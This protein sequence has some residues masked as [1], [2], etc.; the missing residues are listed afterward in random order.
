MKRTF[1]I[2]SLILCCICSMADQYDNQYFG[3]ATTIQ[4]EKAGTL[5]KEL[6]KN[7]EGF[8]I[9]QIKGE[10]SDKDMKTLAKLTYLKKLSLRYANIEKTT[11]FPTLPNLEVLFLP[12][13]QVIPLE[14][15]DM[16][17]TN[18]KIKVLLLSSFIYSS[19]TDVDS[20]G[21]NGTVHQHRFITFSSLQKVILSRNSGLKIIK[22]KEYGLQ[23]TEPILVDTIVYSPQWSRNDFVSCPDMFK[24]R[25]YEEING[26]LFY[27][28]NEPVDFS[29]VEAVKAPQR[30]WVN[31][32]GEKTTRYFNRPLIPQKLDLRKM[33]YVGKNYFNDTDVEEITFSSTAVEFERGGSYGIYSGAFSG[34]PKLKKI[35]FAKSLKNLSIPA[36]TFA[37]CPNLETIVFDCPVTI[38][39]AAFINSNKIKEVVFNAYATVKSN[40]FQKE[41]NVLIDNKLHEIIPIEKVTFNAPASIQ[42]NAF[43]ITDKVIFNVMPT[44][45]DIDFAKCKDI[46]IPKTD[47]AYD[48][49]LAWGFNSEFL[50]SPNANLKLDIIVTEPGNIL[51][52]MPIDKLTQII[53]LTITGHLYDTDIEIIKQCTNLQYLNLANTYISESP[54]TQERRQ[55]EKEMWNAMAEI[56]IAEAQL[57]EA[58][59]K[60]NKRQVKQ[61]VADAV[62]TAAAM[63]SHYP[64]MPDCHIPNSAFS[65]MLR[66]KEVVLP[67]VA[68]QINM[69]AFKGCKALHKVNLG[70]SLKVIGRGA[71]EDTHL[72]DIKFPVTLKTIQV[73]AFENVSSLTSLDLSNCTMETY[74]GGGIYDYYKNTKIGCCNNVTTLYMPKGMEEFNYI[75]DNN[76]IN[77]KDVYVGQDVKRISEKIENINLHFQ[78]E[79]APEIH[80][81][82]K[83]SNCTIYVPRNAN[84][85]SYYAKFN[86][87]GN[88]II[89]Q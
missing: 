3:N 7:L 44:S 34:T 68:V 51:N 59:G 71:F 84:I 65:N 4:L 86:N 43:P 41:T 67:I 89:Q 31:E 32:N 69:Y 8:T 17:P 75:I 13:D 9:L 72:S 25:L 76:C 24:A 49:F 78:T 81:M 85:T 87:N 62:Y 60:Y 36:G 73:E 16:I 83:V 22:Y 74:Y 30:G 37:N 6:G 66:L 45:L 29:T 15:F 38:E 56:S 53:S 80:V 88:K 35:T 46:T 2:C 47:E 48:K 79:Y 55:E 70:D 40:A 42:K 77:I 64:D 10:L 21:Q 12:D 1:I 28:G 11:Y 14:Y 39:S 82:G 26:H 27:I 57:G 33:T 54:Q 18:S 63:L 58:T 19:F 23:S 5:S 61:Q 20:W 52:F 50:N